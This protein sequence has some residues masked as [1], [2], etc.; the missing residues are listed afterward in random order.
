MP[1]HVGRNA[2]PLRR[3]VVHSRCQDQNSLIKS[4][5]PHSGSVGWFVTC[6]SVRQT[7]TTWDVTQLGMLK[8]ASKGSTYLNE[9]PR[10]I[11]QGVSVQR[12]AGDLH[13]LR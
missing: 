10:S 9:V 4:S 7:R 8:E 5:F 12:V 6:Q 2:T 13:R 1:K 3:G 11:V